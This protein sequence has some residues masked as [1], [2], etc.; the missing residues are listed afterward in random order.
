MKCIKLITMLIVT[1]FCAN[2]AVAQNAFNNRSDNIVGTY[3][4]VQEGYKF[5]AKIV[6]LTDGSYR[7]QVFW[8][9]K[10]RDEQG[11]KLLDT[12]N[13]DRSLRSTPADRVVLFSG[14]TYDEKRHEW[15]G[16]KI[17]DPIRGIRAKMVATFTA[18]GQLR[19]K[20]SLLGISESVYWKPLNR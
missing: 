19:I 10:D 11:N 14:L 9:E 4:G 18:D 15:N 7:G 13:P 8:M 6:K 16:C 1:L 5:K 2:F 12:K 17:Y 20:G 3:E